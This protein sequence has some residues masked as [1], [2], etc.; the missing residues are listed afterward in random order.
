M[1]AAA[2]RMLDLTDKDPDPF[3]GM[4]KMVFDPNKRYPF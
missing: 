4:L 2:K 3:L 1:Q